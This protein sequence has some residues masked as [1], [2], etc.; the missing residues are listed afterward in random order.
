MMPSELLRLREEA[1]LRSVAIESR[2]KGHSCMASRNAPTQLVACCAPWL[3]WLEAFAGMVLCEILA[4]WLTKIPGEPWLKS[5]EEAAEVT[6][7]GCRF[8]VSRRLAGHRVGADL[9]GADLAGAD[10]AGAAQRS[11]STAGPCGGRRLNL[12][13]R[14]RLLGQPWCRRR[15]EKLARYPARSLR[16]S[17]RCR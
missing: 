1:P 2:E 6:F 3:P 7:P 17:R 10:L 11:K 12:S 5:R 4:L 16:K 13:A 14:E 8:L 15:L 9:A